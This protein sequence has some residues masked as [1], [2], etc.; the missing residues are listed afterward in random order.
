MED[1][2][3]V[4]DQVSTMDLENIIIEGTMSFFLI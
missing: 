3:V 4:K 1:Y 2:A